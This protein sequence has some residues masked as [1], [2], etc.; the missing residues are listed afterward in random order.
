MEI[1]NEKLYEMYNGLKADNEKLYKMYAGLKTDVEKLY[2]M[3]AGLKT[4]VEKLYR[5]NVE[6]RAELKTEIS[7][8]RADIT[9]WGAALFAGSMVVMTTILGVFIASVVL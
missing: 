1:T 2:E 3:H 5:M 6:T 4:D 9:K 8:L 7:Q